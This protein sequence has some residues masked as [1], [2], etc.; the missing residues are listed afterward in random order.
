METGHLLK[1]EAV[2]VEYKKHESDRDGPVVLTIEHLSA[3]VMIYTVALTLAFVCFIGERLAHKNIMRSNKNGI[4]RWMD[5]FIFSAERVI[6]KKS[7]K[8]DIEEEREG[9]AVAGGEEEEDEEEI[10]EV[11]GEVDKEIDD[12][13]IDLN[14]NIQLRQSLTLKSRSHSL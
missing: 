3:A 7:Y 10:K 9:E 14:R 4:W 6:C 11:R 2:N 1:W 13:S 8:V 5:K 12:G